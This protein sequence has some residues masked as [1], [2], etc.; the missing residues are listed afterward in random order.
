MNAI[1]VRFVSFIFAHGTFI[2]IIIFS[3]SALN[4]LYKK[5]KQKF[6]EIYR[7]LG[8]F[9]FLYLKVIKAIIKNIKLLLYNN[10]FF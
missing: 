2:V 8:N 4:I 7:Y 5:M 6:D 9:T 1:V 3:I 10:L